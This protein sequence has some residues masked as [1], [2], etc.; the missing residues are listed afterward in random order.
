MNYVIIF[1]GGIGAR[2]GSSIP[3]QFLEVDQKEI[4]VHTIEKFNFHSEIDKIVVVS[5]GD[6]MDY[7]RQLMQK[8]NLY[9]VVEVVSGGATGQQSIYNGLKYLVDHVSKDVKNDIVL[10][11]DGVRPMI[12]NNLISNSINMCK[13]KGNS[14]AVARAIETIVR[15]GGDGVLKDVVD[16]SECWYAKAPQCFK[17]IDLWN[18]HTW[19]IKNNNFAFIDSATLMS[20][21]GFELNTV[22]CSAEN[23]KITTP[24]DYYMF[25]AIYE[26]QK[27]D[28][29]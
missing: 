4:L 2:M 9:K 11:H 7:C 8:Y 25:K 27:M 16:R 1:A 12:D 5:N 19:A 26:A 23:I 10:V 24:N 3:K 22:E 29:H 6:Y 14:I 17:A 15:I 20:S 18:A 21:F 28:K 13:S